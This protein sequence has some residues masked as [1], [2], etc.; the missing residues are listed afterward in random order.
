MEKY[1]VKIFFT[2]NSATTVNGVLEE[3]LNHALDCIASFGAG[4]D[5]FVVLPYFMGRIN[6]IREVLWEVEE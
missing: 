1:T 3:E 6:M 5:R 2:D 4:D